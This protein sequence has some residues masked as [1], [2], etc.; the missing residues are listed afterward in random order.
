M[1]ALVAAA[2]KGGKGLDKKKASNPNADKTCGHCSKKGHVKE[3]CWKE[4]PDKIS[5]KV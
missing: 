4:V 3:D 1:I 2:K 5:E